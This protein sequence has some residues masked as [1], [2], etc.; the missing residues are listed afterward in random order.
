ML[1]RLTLP[2]A[3]GPHAT[4]ACGA[5]LKNTACLL[6]GRDSLWSPLHGDLGDPANCDA[7]DASLDALVAH[8]GAAGAGRIAAVAHDLHPDFH[9]TRV[10]VAWADRLGVPAVG[11]QHHHAHVAAVQ[12][13]CG[14]AGPVVGLALDGVGLGTDGTAWGGELLWVDGA[15]MRRLGHLPV[16]ALPGGDAA[17][18]DPWRMA[19]ALLH[20]AGRGGEIGPRL[21]PAVGEASARGVQAMLERGLHCPATTGAGRWFDAAAGLLGICHRQ[22]HEAEAAIALERLAAQHLAEQ[23]ALADDWHGDHGLDL[24]PLLPTLLA[25]ADGGQAAR[26][27]ALFH[28]VLADGLARAA[29][30]AAAAHGLGAVVLSGGCF[31]NRVL[32]QRVSQGLAARGLQVLRPPVLSCGD[33]GL[34]LGQAWVAAQALQAPARADFAPTQ[35]AVESMLET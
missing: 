10:A 3:A 2:Q 13:E 33:A 29:A 11:V 19:A 28:L 23:P 12:A 25:C 16:L 15:A 31:F 1:T 5:W 24:L 34:A 35:A 21:A 26:G 14:H 22:T 9:S 7:L 32:A 20:A 30:E 27:A 18:R 17:A 4:L 8:A 6:D